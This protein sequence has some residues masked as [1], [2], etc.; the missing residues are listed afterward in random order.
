MSNNFK[1]KG[2]LEETLECVLPYMLWEDK[3]LK[4][5]Y[6]GKEAIKKCKDRSTAVSVQNYNS[7]TQ[8]YWK[9]YLFIALSNINHSLINI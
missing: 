9:L 7:I 4:L 2:Q 1:C 5:L 6:L 8:E 3:Y